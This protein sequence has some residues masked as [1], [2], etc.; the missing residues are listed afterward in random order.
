[1]KTT[2]KPSDDGKK[3]KKDKKDKKGKKDKKDKEGE[4]AAKEAAK[5]ALK[6]QRAEET[7]IKK[8]AANLRRKVVADSTKVVAK[9]QPVLDELEKHLA[10]KHV[11]S[12]PG[13]AVKPAAASL[14][15]LADWKT[16]A[17]AALGD[18]AVVSLGFVVENVVEGVSEAKRAGKTLGDFLKV[19]EKNT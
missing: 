3:D 8:E 4:K 11:K 7:R 5:A 14:K 6:E 18:T 2:S 12:V 9:V 1:M 19:C 15:K 16:R 13:Y 17:A 10:S